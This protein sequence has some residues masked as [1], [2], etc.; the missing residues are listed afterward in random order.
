MPEQLKYEYF[1]Y[2]QAGIVNPRKRQHVVTWDRVRFVSTNVHAGEHPS[3]QTMI[4]SDEKKPIMISYIKTNLW[5]DQFPRYAQVLKLIMAKVPADKIDDKLPLI[6]QYATP[7][8][9]YKSRE[10]M[11]KQ[12]PQDINGLKRFARMAWVR[13]DYGKARKYLKMALMINE[14]DISC[15][16]DM[17]EMDMESH[18]SHKQ[19]KSCL[20]QILKMDP[21]HPKAL[22]L[23]VAILVSLDS[24]ETEAFIRRAISANPRALALQEMLGAWLFRKE[25]FDEAKAVMAGIEGLS[26][27][28]L[29]RQYIQQSVEYIHKYQTDGD[30]RKKE[31]SNYRKRVFRDWLIAAAVV[32]TLI[33]FVALKIIF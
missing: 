16:L 2:D 21:E 19:V 18:K 3:Y 8:K 32:L 26:D 9:E 15:L 14:R 20:D 17:A 31:K 12:N 27:D 1:H 5:F 25:R 30:F 24:P 13:L 4:A 23:M 6:V 10:K 11:A 22:R 7:Y 28:G 29:T 33:L